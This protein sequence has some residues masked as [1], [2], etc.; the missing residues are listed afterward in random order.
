MSR[1]EAKTR[2]GLIDK[3]LSNKMVTAEIKSVSSNPWCESN[4]LKKAFLEG[5]ERAGLFSADL[6]ED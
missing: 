6:E 4:F 5:C 1:S 3:F 2:A